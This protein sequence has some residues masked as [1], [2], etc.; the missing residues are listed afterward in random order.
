MLMSS[1]GMLIESHHQDDDVI[2]LYITSCS[3]EVG[4][5]CVIVWDYESVDEV[6]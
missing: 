4:S 3:M 5:K 6:V 1:N 2:I